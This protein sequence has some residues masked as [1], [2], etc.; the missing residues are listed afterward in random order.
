MTT[1]TALDWVQWLRVA[2]SPELVQGLRDGRVV[3]GV[4]P[5]LRLV[6]RHAPDDVTVESLVLAPPARVTVHATVRKHV[7]I[8]I[9]LPLDLVA[10]RWS[11][12]E[13]SVT[14]ACARD[15]VAIDGDGLIASVVLSIGLALVRLRGGDE[16]SVLDERLALALRAE[17]V[18][19]GHR[20]DL[21]SFPAVAA[22]LDRTVGPLALWSVVSFDRVECTADAVV[23]HPSA[24]TVA[25]AATW[26]AEA[27]EVA[28]KTAEVWAANDGDLKKT[29]KDLFAA[30]LGTWRSRS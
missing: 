29:A 20:V 18:P 25:R 4:E 28:R 3:L 8:R 7:P 13:A 11:Q 22:E 1:M 19:G 27:A 15:A 14:Y 16:A 6:R 30:A 26:K 17:A 23:V 24:E 21:R 5:L 2:A 12:A 9:A 10:L